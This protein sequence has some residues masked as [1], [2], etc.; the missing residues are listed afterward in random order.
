MFVYDDLGVWLVGEVIGDVCVVVE[1]VMG[2]EIIGE[3]SKGVV[4]VVVG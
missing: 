1:D 2:I 4:F 3:M